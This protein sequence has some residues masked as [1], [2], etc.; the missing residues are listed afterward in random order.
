MAHD[1]GHKPVLLSETI[2]ALAVKPDG[3]YVDGT[4]G[5]AGHTREILALGGKVL[6]I[7][8]D[9]QALEE[10]ARIAG[11]EPELF[12]KLSVAKGRHGDLKRLVDEKGWKKVDGILL[13]LGVS[14]PQ[15]DEAGRGFSFLR[16]GPLDMRMDRAEGV[17]AADIVNDEGAGDLARI[18][19]DLGEEPQAGRIAKAIVASRTKKR[20]ETTLELADFIERL[21][22]RRGGHH[23]ATRVF[24]ALRMAVNDEMGE[25]E[26]ALED[27]MSILKPGGRF[28]IITFESLT[29]RVVKRFFAAHVGRMVS[30]QQGGERW[31]GALPRA[32]AVTRKAVRAAEEEVNL[33]PRSRSAKLRVIEVKEN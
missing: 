31:E 17:S 32:V 2:A 10:V 11:V 21:I 15:L 19:R 22:G 13:D 1:T 33:N 24:Q 29:D 7:D 28:A 23:P 16:D 12:A 14:S 30:L 3:L 9:D 26:K 27:G 6:G 8:R 20:F 25:L 5:R 18:F 4:L